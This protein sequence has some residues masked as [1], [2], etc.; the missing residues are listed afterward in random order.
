MCGVEKVRIWEHSALLVML[1][2]RMKSVSAFPRAMHTIFWCTVHM[3]HFEYWFTQ[4]FRHEE[5]KQHEHKHASLNSAR[6]TSHYA[7]SELYQRQNQRGGRNSKHG[8]WLEA[9]V[10]Q[11]CW[12]KEGT[13]LIFHLFMHHACWCALCTCLIY[14]R[15]LNHSGKAVSPRYTSQ[16]WSCLPNAAADFSWKEDAFISPLNLQKWSSSGSTVAQ[17]YGTALEL[18]AFVLTCCC[19]NST[20]TSFTLWKFAAALSLFLFQQNAAE[21][22]EFQLLS[23][24]S[25]TNQQHFYQI[26]F[27]GI[28]SYCTDVCYFFWD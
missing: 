6:N 23:R 4:N 12:R 1:I 14:F 17:K 24:W 16:G 9:V 19:L 28:A 20:K 7:V 5:C 15:F 21:K 3:E 8:L 2:R 27:H 26:R 11:G 25:V 13:Q 18:S 10:L 22:F